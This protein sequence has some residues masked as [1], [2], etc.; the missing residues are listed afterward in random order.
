[1]FSHL[2]FSA[3]GCL[4]VCGCHC[5]CHPVSAVIS[6]FLLP[7]LFCI[8]PPLPP[9]HVIVQFLDL[10]NFNM[11]CPNI[12]SRFILYEQCHS[13]IFHFIKFWNNMLF[14]CLFYILNVIISTVGV[15]TFLDMYNLILKARVN[16]CSWCVLIDISP[17]CRSH[18]TILVFKNSLICIRYII[19]SFSLWSQSWNFLLV[20]WILSHS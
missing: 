18:F 9:C 4:C 1:M 17:G 10:S 2:P 20:S 19:E 5:E 12:S 8:T 13:Q 3:L 14:L 6:E 16:L 7:L 15:F 11:V